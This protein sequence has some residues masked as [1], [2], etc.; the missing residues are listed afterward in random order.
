MRSDPYER[1]LDRCH[2]ITAIIVIQF[3]HSSTTKASPS[4]PDQ[5]VPF[6]VI[7]CALHVQY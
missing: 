1:C 5:A 6:Y 7:I 4:N 3:P 2:S